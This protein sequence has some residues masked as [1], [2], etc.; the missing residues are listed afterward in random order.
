[1][2]L[3]WDSDTHPPRPQK[4]MA[5][6]WQCPSNWGEVRVELPRSYKSP[7][8]GHALNGERER[9]QAAKCPVPQGSGCPAGTRAGPGQG[10]R[11]VLAWIPCSQ[12][13]GRA[14]RLE[15]SRGSSL[16]ITHIVTALCVFSGAWDR[17]DRLGD[18]KIPEARTSSPCPQRRFRPSETLSLALLLSV[19]QTQMIS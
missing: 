4:S 16:G 3:A 5:G 14:N 19:P 13:G 11:A 8:Q 18:P 2:G 6:R 10:P 17:V 15:F 7:S 12:V 9:A 1:M